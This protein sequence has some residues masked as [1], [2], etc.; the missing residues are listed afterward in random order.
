MK[1]IKAL[2][3]IVLCFFFSIPTFS[4]HQKKM[5]AVEKTYRFRVVLTDKKNNIY[6]LRHPEKF[7]SAKALERR[8]RYKIKVDHY[9]LPV[10]PN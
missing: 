2:G 4:Q 8:R 9:D 6:T 3:T 7:L 1:I 5:Q 10:S